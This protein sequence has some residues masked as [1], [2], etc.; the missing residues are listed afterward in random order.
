[1]SYDM[2]CFS[3][4]FTVSCRPWLSQGSGFWG[5]SDHRKL[6]RVS[7]QK[8]FLQMV[9][10]C[11]IGQMCTLFSHAQMRFNTLR[12]RQNGRHFSDDIFKCIFFNGNLWIPIRISLKFVPRGSIDNKWTLVLVM[13]WRRTGDKPL[14]EPMMTQFSDTYMRHP[15]VGFVEYHKYLM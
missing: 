5:R 8:Y 11:F 9:W 13:A 12:P 14:P 7:G 3:V 15:A 4:S 10:S 1:M 6:S 2:S